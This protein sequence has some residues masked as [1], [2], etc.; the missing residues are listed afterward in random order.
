MKLRLVLSA[1]A[2]AFTAFA[3]NPV[4]AQMNMDHSKMGMAGMPSMTD[5]EVRKIDKDAGKI[6]IKHGELKDLGMMP[7]TMVFK[8]KEPAMLDKVSPGAKVRFSAEKVQGAVT[9][10]A[11]EVVK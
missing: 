5:G 4:F 6:T 8:V 10:T 9:V 11:L 1:T 2:L 3:A 7:M